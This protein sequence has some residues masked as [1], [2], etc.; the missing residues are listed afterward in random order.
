MKLVLVMIS[1]L[2]SVSACAADKVKK[3]AAKEPEKISLLNEPTTAF[4]ADEKGNVYVDGKIVAHDAR[5]FAA[6]KRT[7]SQIAGL[8]QNLQGCAQQLQKAQ[9]GAAKKDE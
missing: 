6:L 5:V 7:Q 9:A 4:D 8:Q 3:E 1:V 2:F